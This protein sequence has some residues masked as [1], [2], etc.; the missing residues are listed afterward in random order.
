MRRHCVQTCAPCA[1]PVASPTEDDAVGWTAFEEAQEPSDAMTMIAP[2]SD[3]GEP[4]VEAAADEAAA[5]EAAAEEE[6]AAVPETA[7]PEPEPDAE[8]EPEPEPVVEAAVEAEAAPRR[9]WFR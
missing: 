1:A 5:D 6:E 7:A 3:E 2:A 4:V 8:P 9:R